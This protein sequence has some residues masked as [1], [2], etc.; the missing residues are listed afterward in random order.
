MSA[1]GVAFSLLQPEGARH[2]ESARRAGM[3]PV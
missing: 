2:I 1:A 3:L